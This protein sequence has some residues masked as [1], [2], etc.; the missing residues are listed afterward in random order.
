MSLT[1]FIANKNYS[2][3][4]LRPWLLMRVL[5][6]PFVEQLSPFTATGTGQSFKAVSPTGK[7][8]CLVDGAAVVW[9]SLSIVEY[10]A[11]RYPAV[12]PAD[13]LAR[14][15][16]RS[17]SAEMHSGF[18]TLRSVCGMSCGVRVKLSSYP[19]KLVD[20]M[21]RLDE[22]WNEGL[23]RFG[24]DYLAGDKF[25]AVDAFFAP[26]AF[27]IQTY[28]LKPGEMAM[29]YARR[30]LALPAMQQWYQEALQEP[31]R[32]PPHERRI[33]DVGTII[34]DLRGAV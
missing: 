32:D 15:W 9:D 22:L 4:S 11:E 31:W 26:I 18:A 16:A 19:D 17:A 23:V 33:A 8:P 24:G 7:V 6:I 13:P 12:W 25:T 10:L 34:D 14:A 5:D 3:W 20:D 28:G 30:L 2:S 27:R 1:L 29:Q 21:R